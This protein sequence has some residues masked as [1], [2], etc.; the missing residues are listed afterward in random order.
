MIKLNEEITIFKKKIFFLK[1]G[2]KKI[3]VFDLTFDVFNF[4]CK[5]II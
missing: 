5:F 1:R 4:F 3:K 2:I